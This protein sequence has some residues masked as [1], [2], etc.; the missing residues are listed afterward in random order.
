MFL[1][2]WKLLFYLTALPDIVASL[3]SNQQAFSIEINKIILSHHTSSVDSSIIACAVSC[4]TDYNCC[5][6]SY[7]ED[8][9]VCLLGN[10]CSPVMEDSTSFKTL[11][12][13]PRDVAYG[14]SAKQSSVFRNLSTNIASRAVDGDL[15]TWMHTETE[16]MPFWIVDLEKIYKIKQIEV[17]NRKSFHKFVVERLHDLDITVGA[18]E[19]ELKLCAHY[20]GPSE[21]GEHLVFQCKQEDIRY[22]K[23][24]ING[25]EILHV[26]EVK[27]YAW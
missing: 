10:Q 7:N 18:T 17:F 6:A 26:A 2:R 1:Q 4:F 11:T 19:N 3:K 20:V 24:M 13:Q 16:Y 8:S 12:K 25:T 5:S 21:N 27:V 9:K 23:L 15:N 14:K 22:V